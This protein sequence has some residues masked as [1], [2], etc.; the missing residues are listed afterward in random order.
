MLSSQVFVFYQCFRIVPF[1]AE[2]TAAPSCPAV[3]P[4]R[5]RLAAESNDGNQGAHTT[6]SAIGTGVFAQNRAH[7]AGRCAVDIKGDEYAALIAAITFGRPRQHRKSLSFGRE[8]HSRPGRTADIGASHEPQSCRAARAGCDAIGNPKMAREFS[9]SE[10]AAC[11]SPPRRAY[12]PQRSCGRVAEGGGLLNRYRVVKPY[13][14]FE[15]L[16]LRHPSP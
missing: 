4:F 5:H 9:R 12:P 6:R 2:I 8:A 7:P 10:F 11:G 16:R 14:G 15:S 3:F 13:R 1:G